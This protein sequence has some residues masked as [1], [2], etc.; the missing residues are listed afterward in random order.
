MIPTLPRGRVKVPAPQGRAGK[1]WGVSQGR[2]SPHPGS[3]QGQNITGRQGCGGCDQR[4]WDSESRDPEGDGRCSE[5][6]LGVRMGVGVSGGPELPSASPGTR[7]MQAGKD[8]KIMNPNRH[9]AD[10]LR[11]KKQTPDPGAEPS[12]QKKLSIRRWQ[13]GLSNFSLKDETGSPPGRAFTSRGS[14]ITASKKL[15]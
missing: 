1:G 6:N 2:D 13:C 3:P 8:Q 10:G 5:Q 9:P 4:G 11:P 12:A 14:S 15:S 7:Y